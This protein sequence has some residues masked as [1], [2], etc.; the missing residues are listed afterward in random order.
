MGV[1][2]PR[3]EAHEVLAVPG[4]AARD[5][6][7]PRHQRPPTAAAAAGGAGGGEGPGGRRAQRQVWAGEVRGRP[8][9]CGRMWEGR[10]GHIV[11]A[12]GER[13]RE[14]ETKRERQ[15]QRERITAIKEDRE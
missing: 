3:Q 10:D 7:I 8:R 11:P 2:G 13:Q 1:A 14:T 5:E 9:G 12:M 4:Q 15:R 6:G